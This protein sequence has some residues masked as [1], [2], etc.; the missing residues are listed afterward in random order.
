MNA[1]ANPGNAGELHAPEESATSLHIPSVLL[2]TGLAFWGWQ[3]NNAYAAAGLAL[4]LL[5]PVFTQLRLDLSVRD[6][7][8]ISDLTMILYVAVAAS[9]IATEGLRAGSAKTDEVCAPIDG[10]APSRTRG[11][12][13][14]VPN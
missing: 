13:E 4:T 2:A 9:L 6:Q 14:S 8:R 3:T 1:D 7:Q 10:A 12:F 5:L 11:V